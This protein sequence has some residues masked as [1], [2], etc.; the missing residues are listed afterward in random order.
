MRIVPWF[1]TLP[2]LAGRRGQG[3]GCLSFSPLCCASLRLATAF[4]ACTHPKKVPRYTIHT[5]F[6][7][8]GRSSC[9]DRMASRH[10]PWSGWEEWREVGRLLS[11][12]QQQEATCADHQQQRVGLA[13]VSDKP[14]AERIPGLLPC[15]PACKCDRYFLLLLVAGRGMAPPWAR[16]TCSGRHSSLGAG[17]ADRAGHPCRWSAWHRRHDPTFT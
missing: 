7:C 12:L 8:P 11:G 2:R 5:Q 15:N 1:C 13:R 9:Q 4:V 16:A 10:V 6:A 14:S 17:T 3:P